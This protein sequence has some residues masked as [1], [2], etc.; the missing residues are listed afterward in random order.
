MPLHWLPASKSALVVSCIALG[1]FCPGGA[2]AEDTAS[3]DTT[4]VEKTDLETPDPVDEVVVEAPIPVDNVD[5]KPNP[6]DSVPN[7][8]QDN[9]DVGDEYQGMAEAPPMDTDAPDDQQPVPGFETPAALPKGMPSD[10]LQLQLDVKINGA[11][12]GYV[13]AFYQRPDGDLVATRGELAQLRIVAPGEGGPDEW[14]PINSLPTASFAYDEAEQSIDI[15]IS[16]EQRALQKLNARKT[17]EISEATSGNGLLLNYTLFS[18]L[19]ADYGLKHPSVSGVSSFLESRLFTKWG[20]LQ[21]SGVIATPDFAVAETIRL[22]TTVYFEDPKRMLE[23][24]L[25]DA[26]S[27]GTNWSRPVRLGGGQVRRNFAMRPDLI[28]MPIPEISGTAGVPS[29]LDVYVGNARA[30]SGE[31]EEGPFVLPNIPIFTNEGTARVVLTDATGREVESEGEFFTSP[32]LLNPGLFDFSAEV[33]FLRERYGKNSFDYSEYPVGIASMRY[34]LTHLLTAEAHVEVSEDVQNGGIGFLAAIPKFGTLNAAAA[35]SLYDGDTGF[36]LYGSWEKNWGPI[37]LDMSTKR[38][39]GNYHDLASVNAFELTGKLNSGIP[40]ALD[41]I[42]VGYAIPEWDASV[43]MSFVHVLARDDRRD[44]ILAGSISKTFGNI[45]VSGGGFFNFG[46][47]EDYG[48]AVGFSMPLGKTMSASSGAG[49][50]KDGYELGGSISKGHSDKKFSTSWNVAY[51]WNDQHRVAASGEMLTPVGTANADVRANKSGVGG[52]LGF[53]GAAVVTSVGLL[54]GRHVGNSFAIVDAGVPGV[55]VKHQNTFVGETGRGGQLLVPSIA[56]YLDNKFE[57]DLDS[58]AL[59]AETPE[60]EKFVTP[61][62]RSGVLV[63]FKVTGQT[64]AAIIKI[65]DVDGKSI[66]LSTEIFLEGNAEPFVMGY[67]GEVYVT[68]LSE[69]NTLLVMLASGACKVEF[70]YTGNAQEQE[71]IGPLKCV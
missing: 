26:I 29:T 45:N 55:K 64:N 54:A 46:K 10:Y 37:T 65:E 53:S 25:G 67:D 17:G 44:L 56:P 11:P 34:G 23:Y 14:F 13:S 43:G 19:N 12:T 8:G 33:G 21:V 62:A 1:L 69:R 59:T 41:Q 24:Q 40:I 68:A 4:S 42:S 51:D 2:R 27:G 3:A 38:T 49:L 71:F 35:A 66:P 20:T 60:S 36:L 52:T 18:A 22:D 50:T 16:A 39:F 70:D 9:I 47:E 30:F 28:T 63:D 32:N 61:R 31:V 5:E 48:L 6:Q 57:V 15:R 58:M 7:S